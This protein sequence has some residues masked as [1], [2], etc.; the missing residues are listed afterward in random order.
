[1]LP[2]STSTLQDE[3][4]QVLELLKET[5]EDLT[6]C[7]S[8][9]LAVVLRIFSLLSPPPPSR[10]SPLEAQTAAT[11]AAA[12][13]KL[14]DEK[15]NSYPYKDVPR[16][17]R[18][19]YTDA[20]LLEGVARLFEGEA[21]PGE[22]DRDR[23][24]LLETVRDCDL[25]IIIA[26]APGHARE[27]FVFRLIA[28]AQAR[29]ASL[30]PSTTTSP[31]STAGD[32][33]PTKRPR[34]PSP[35]R[36]RPLPPPYIARPVT[37]LPFLPSFLLPSTVGT[38][39]QPFIVR[40]ACADWPAISHPASRWRSPEYLR[41]VGGEGRV[42][43]VEVGGDYTREGWGQGIVG[44]GEF[45]DSTFSSFSRA[46]STIASDPDPDPDSDPDPDDPRPMYYLAQHSLFAQFP[47]LKADLFVP[48]LVYSAPADNGVGTDEGY[49]MNAWLGPQGTVSPAHTDP[50]WNC[51]TQVVG[52]KWIWVAP[53][54]CGPWM[55][56]FGS[57]SPSESDASTCGASCDRSDDT[58]AA[59]EGR[60][61]EE[62]EEED[63]GAA[64]AQGYMTNTS[65]LDVT[66]APLG[67]AA[68]PDSLATAPYPPS[69]L[70]R[71]EPLARQVVL[72]EGDV[73]VM[74]PGW[75]HA[76]KSLETS[77]SVSIWF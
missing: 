44:W 30:S 55:A 29:L 37:T 8:S 5:Q 23:A 38:H 59:R 20:T 12:L 66:I 71:V 33:R 60:R 42:V 63:G 57:S 39:A 54:E 35:P 68:D 13:L 19:L 62:K 22:R 34:L 31:S 40:N 67:P 21:G 46:S 10:P 32:P 14:S 1:M 73:L 72:E 41:R 74:P 77:F 53:P 43:P 7:G 56:A 18:R 36:S 4:Q 28:L 51:Y 49:V 11:L 48:D 16:C 69:F 76:M 27:T 58:K 65:S 50:W 6:P 52:S 45:L 25:A 26:G 75:W 47:A 64:P 70:S 61:E 9:A 3:L 24:S 17:W 2:H 15:L